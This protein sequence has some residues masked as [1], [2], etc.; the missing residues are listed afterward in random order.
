MTRRRTRQ[1]RS[2]SQSKAQTISRIRE[3]QR[4][5]RCPKCGAESN[6]NCVDDNGAD[7]HAVH[8]ARQR[9]YREMNRPIALANPDVPF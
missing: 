4:Q 7:Q 8:L 2:S 5:V 1:A 3:Y 9:A 6:T